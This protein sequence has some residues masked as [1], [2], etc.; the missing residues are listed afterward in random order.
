MP[1]R[2]W[3]Q[4]MQAVV[5]LPHSQQRDVS[6]WGVLQWGQRQGGMAHSVATPERD[7]TR[8]SG[9]VRYWTVSTWR[10]VVVVTPSGSVTRTLARPLPVPVPGRD[11]A[12]I[13]VAKAAV[14]LESVKNTPDTMG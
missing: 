12:G 9:A 1:R 3:R 14:P 7:V 2:K 6:G 10:A 11:G 4:A 8:E 5:I 13:V